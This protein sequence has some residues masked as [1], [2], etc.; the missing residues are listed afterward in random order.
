[1]RFTLVM[2]TLFVF[3]ISK[4]QSTYVPDDNFEQRLIDLGYDNIL[5]DSVLTSSIDTVTALTVGVNS[6]FVYDLT[7]IEDFTGLKYLNCAYNELSTL[8]VSNNLE[9]EFLYCFDNELSTLDVS[10]NLA[11][12]EL[13]CS[14]NDITGL[15][16][17]NNLMLKKL[18]C[19]SNNIMSLDLSNNNMLEELFVYHNALTDLNLSNG[20]NEII[21]SL[22]AENNEGL[23]CIQVDHV[24]YSNT[25]WT[26]DLN[27]SFDL[28]TNFSEDCSLP[29]E[30]LETNLNPLHIYPNPLKNVLNITSDK[31]TPYK[32]CS[33]VGS[34]IILSGILK[35]GKNV[36]N[37]A[38]LSE[39][40]Y[41]LELP[42][43]HKDRNIIKII[44]T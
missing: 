1:M 24:N 31:K 25:F 8:D 23:T 4:G 35:E 5:D 22:K 3:G 27:Y 21:A 11:L 26:G 37:L 18:R 15:N 39:G 30:V 2:I 13:D 9:L 17:S 33:I 34:E 12:I 41:L 7:G 28:Q 43:K 10:N 29:L 42:L 36:L 6:M 40:M 16:V 44:K 19:G 38:H 14:V 32:I 20:N